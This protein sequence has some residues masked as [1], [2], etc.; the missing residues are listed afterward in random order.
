MQTASGVL[1]LHALGRQG[2]CERA[3]EIYKTLPSNPGPVL[4]DLQSEL[5]RQYV[6]FDTP[7]HEEEWLIK[8][9][10]KYLLLAA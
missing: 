4:M 5:H 10:I 3:A 8:K 7:R 9:E 1:K 2:D 6:A